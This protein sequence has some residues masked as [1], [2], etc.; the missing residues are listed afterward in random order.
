[1]AKKEKPL[2]YFEVNTWMVEDAISTMDEAMAL[3]GLIARDE[4][5]FRQKSLYGVLTVLIVSKRT[6]NEYLEKPDGLE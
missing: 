4:D 6:L 3:I 2:N 1:M 5:P